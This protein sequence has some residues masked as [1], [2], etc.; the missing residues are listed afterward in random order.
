MKQNNISTFLGEQCRKYRKILGI[1]QE[2]LAEKMNTTPQTISNYERMGIKDVDIEKEISSIL[3][4]NLREETEDNEG[5]PGELGKEILFYLIEHKGNCLIVELLKDDVLYGITRERL[6]H[7]IEKIAK[8]DLCCRDTFKADSSSGECSFVYYEGT[9]N[10]NKFDRLFITA[11]GIVTIKN[12]ATNSYQVERI[13]KCIKDVKSYE[14][15]LATRT[16]GDI[17][18]KVSMAKDMEGYLELRPWYRL[19]NE[20]ARKGVCNYKADYIKYLYTNWMNKFEFA[21]PWLCPGFSTEEIDT[22][23]PGKNFYYDLMYRMAFGFT[24]K[25]R[26][27]NNVVRGAGNKCVSYETACHLYEGEMVEKNIENKRSR[28]DWFKANELELVI[29]QEE[30]VESCED[31]LF[32]DIMVECDNDEFVLSANVEM[33]RNPILKKLSYKKKLTDKYESEVSDEFV[34][35]VME[36]SR[37]LFYTLPEEPKTG[38]ERKNIVDNIL[39]E[40][41]LR[42]NVPNIEEYPDN[43]LK[44]FTKEQI[45][46][47][48]RENYK[49]PEYYNELIIQEEL[50]E[51]EML[52]P[53]AKEEYYQF[54]KSWE[55]N[56]LADLV[57]EVCCL[58]M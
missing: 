12:S 18:K 22:L 49:K 28:L 21:D 17:L 43:V 51:I 16:H 58:N 4:V 15:L 44:W 40:E 5:T 1:T 45:E 3:G 39:L 30:Y 14:M 31:T 48:I 7:E 2:E 24:N 10:G 46:S 56:G 9:F 35:E 19:I 11:K 25:Y 23:I 6:D 33:G 55:E 29:D 34:D 47:F 53:E 26:C 20:L 50:H 8:L 36:K 52:I 27:E 41:E 54:P 32:E 37:S 42:K 38:I 57:R 13:N